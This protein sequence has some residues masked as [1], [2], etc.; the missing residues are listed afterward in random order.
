MN[1]ENIYGEKKEKELVHWQQKYEIGLPEIDEQHK[2]L[3]GLLNK[4]FDAAVTEK[5]DHN[6]IKT[7][8]E[9]MEDYVKVHFAS[10]E[11]YFKAAKYPK[12]KIHME[13]HRAFEKKVA[14]LRHEFSNSFFDLRDVLDFVKNWFLEHTQ[15]HDREFVDFWKEKMKNEKGE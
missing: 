8:L 6:F 10:E 3:A 14:E 7:I 1:D 2:K 13:Q 15:G 9:E 11:K 12:L 5:R 4:V